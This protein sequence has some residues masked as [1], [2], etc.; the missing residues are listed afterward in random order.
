MPASSRTTTSA[1]PRRERSGADAGQQAG[2]GVRRDPRPLRQPPGGAGRERGTEHA[3]SRCASQAIL[4]AARARVLPAPALPTTTSTP[5]PE[6][7][8]RSTM[9][10]CSPESSGKWPSAPARA[11]AS[12][13]PRRACRS[14]VGGVEERALER[15]EL[16]GGVAH[17]AAPPDARERDDVGDDEDPFGDDLDVAHGGAPGQALGHRP[18]HVAA[19]EGRTRRREPLGTDEAS[20]QVLDLGAARRRPAL[21]AEQ[22]VERAAPGPARLQTEPGGP[23]EPA[24]SQPGARHRL[25]GPWA[26]G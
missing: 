8:R 17:L 22:V 2:Q 16:V 14:P 10:T 19:L 6:V 13:T 11:P 3:R 7:A 26:S 15:Q 9:A 1:G 23:G 4:A 25:R 18:D 21:G 24:L 20:E 5:A 12:A